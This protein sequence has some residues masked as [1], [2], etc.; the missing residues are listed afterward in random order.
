[1]KIQKHPDN[2]W[3]YGMALTRDFFAVSI[4]KIV[5]YIWGSE[6]ENVSK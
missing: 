3:A 2:Y 6:P 5:I 4:Y 1:M